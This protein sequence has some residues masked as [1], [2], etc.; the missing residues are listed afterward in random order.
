[1]RV[2]VVGAGLSGASIANIHTK[3]GDSVNVYSQNIG[4]N[5]ATSRPEGYPVHLHGAHIFHT[6]NND[7]WNFVNQYVNF[8]D[9]RHTVFA[10]TYAGKLSLPF[11]MATY[12]ALFGGNDAEGHRRAIEFDKTRILNPS[13]FEEFATNTIGQ[14]IYHNLVKY[15]TEKQ[16]GKKATE[17]PA[18]IFKRLPMRWNYDNSYFHNSRFQGTCDYTDLIQNLL[19]TSYINQ[20][21]ITLQ[22]LEYLTKISDKV[23][24]TGSL[25]ELFDYE[26]GQLE[27]RSLRFEH[28][29]YTVESGMSVLG[30]S[31]IND[32]TEERRYTRRI[33]HML[34]TP[35][36]NSTKSLVTTEFPEDWVPGKIRYYPI[37]TQ[38]NLDRYQ[39]YLDKLRKLS[40]KIIPAGRLASYK[41]MDMDKIIEQAFQLTNYI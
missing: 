22:G 15:Y 3:R 19:K 40:D 20:D 6:D 17:L 26:F 18:D 34:F 36:V 7:V 21:T 28:E 33:E 14:T 31:V 11:N 10:V 25:D 29:W 30:N 32:C 35:G 23:Y 39:L 41:Y 37:G 24:F 9:Y 12:D 13:N 38:K 2:S 1:M 5:I 8:V 16:W 4:G 27:Y